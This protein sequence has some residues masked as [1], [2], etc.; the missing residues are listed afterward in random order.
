L[1]QKKLILGILSTLRSQGQAPFAGQS[2]PFAE[3]LE[4]A[5]RRKVTA[6]VFTREDVDWQNNRVMGWIYHE[7]PAPGWQ[8]QPFPLPS[9]VYNRIPNRSLEA[10]PAVR[11]FCDRLKKHY[12]PRYFNPGFLDKWDTYRL[13]AGAGNIGCRLPETHIVYSPQII[14][15]MLARYGDIYLKPQANSLGIGI[16]QVV[17]THG[18]KITCYTRQPNGA[19]SSAD[20][21]TVEDLVASLPLL[22]KG[23]PYLAQQTVKLAKYQD[24]PFDIRLLAQKD[25]RGSWRK[26]GWAAR[27]AGPD[28]ITTHVIYGGDRQPVKM[29]LSSRRYTRVLAKV[30]TLVASVTGI[31]EKDWQSNFG[32]LEMDIAVDVNGQL[33]LFEV[34]AKPFKFDENLLRAKSLLRLIHYARF[35]ANSHPSATVKR[36]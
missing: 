19:G 3:L 6:Y 13:L 36:R 2:G 7:K 27:V 26:T 35:L 28:A 16:S 11:E 5:G 8:Q 25:R 12:G 33:W 20:F 34:N 1:A 30:K 21:A 17:K 22:Q 15:Q 29:V 23:V 32:E 31:I 18:G 4:I 24:R 10:D 14:T 9:V